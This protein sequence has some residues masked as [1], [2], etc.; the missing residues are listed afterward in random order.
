MA[1]GQI[2]TDDELPVC[3]VV[4]TIGGGITGTVAGRRLVVGSP[5]F[6]RQ[7]GCQIPPAIERAERETIA[8]TA[9][10][11][12]VAVD[13]CAVAVAGLGD[14]LRPDAAESL[15]RL[16]KLG[17]KIR[18]LSGDHPEVVAAIG[19]QLGIDAADAVGGASPEAK[20]AAVREASA[21]GPVVMVGDG[22]NDAAALSAASVGIAVHGGA[23]ASLAAAHVYL[24]RPGLAPILELMHAARATH[25]GDPPLFRR[26]D[27][28]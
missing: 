3:D 20:L 23:E 9:T 11:V 15:D 17:W 24:D 22:V 8:A 10:P 4:Q 27:L 7:H 28:L 5:K 12:L 18:I 25:G 14:P 6:V 19:R 26:L 21:R 13:G 2:A 1:Q 16:R